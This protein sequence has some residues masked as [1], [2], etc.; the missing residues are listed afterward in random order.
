[1]A[2]DY[3]LQIVHVP[4]GQIVHAWAPGLAAESEFLDELCDRVVAQLQVAR[5]P[6]YRW[7]SASEQGHIVRSAAA[8]LLHD[9]KARV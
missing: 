9:L 4:T 3:R 5:R 6:W 7:F 1:M 8:A 2:S